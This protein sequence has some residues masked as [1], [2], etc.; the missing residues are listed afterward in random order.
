MSYLQALLVL[1]PLA[2]AG[3]KDD[4]TNLAQSNSSGAALCAQAGGTLDPKRNECVCEAGYAWSGA[5]CEAAAASG[6]GDAP[7]GSSDADVVS[8]ANLPP[9]PPPV[10]DNAATVDGGQE[11]EPP[12][13]PS[14]PP[15]PPPPPPRST[16]AEPEAAP[17]S[18]AAK[19][20]LDDAI[21]TRV[22]RDC[23]AAKGQW[24]AKDSY[25]HCPQGRVLVGRVCADADLGLTR[26]LCERAARPGKWRKGVCA[27]SDPASVFS[28]G[29]GGCVPMRLVS[30]ATQRRM[31]ESLVSRGKWDARDGRCVCPAGRLWASELCLRQED[32]SSERVCESD[33][34]QGRWDGRGKRCDC[35][36]GKLWL[37]QACKDVAQ[38]TTRAACTAEINQGTWA[39]D[40]SSCVCPGTMRWEPAGKRCVR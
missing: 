13:P 21:E 31:C 39:E 12:P 33:F 6:Q 16:P 9:G 35:P 18:E 19:H 7:H 29:R 40:A 2:F 4:P 22:R 26:S 15:L 27:C 32:L 28:P 25:C 30:E 38:V 37:D 17:E 23:A 1:A 10:P 5:M 3:C 36:R 20:P 8:P 11:A 14:P 24:I 34:N